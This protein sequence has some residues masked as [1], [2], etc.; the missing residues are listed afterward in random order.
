MTKWSV[1]C[2]TK[3]K[4]GLGIKN[5]KKMNV[6]LLCKWWWKI[7]HEEGLW[8]TIVKAKY[9]SGNNLITLIKHKVDDSPIWSDLLK[10]RHIYL[11]GRS[12][13]VKN[14]KHTLFW[15]EAW[16]KQNPLCSLYSVHYEL[17]LDKYITVN[18]FVLRNA[19]LNFSRWLPTFLFTSWTSLVDEIYS[20]PFENENDVIFWK[21]NN[22][23]KFFHK[24]SL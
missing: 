9:M 18:Q 12:T 15:E 23:G 3:R 5:I 2:K 11:R 4:G 22:N 21:L 7:E 10:I 19:Q 24:V 20:Y 6:S 17:C 16:F 8:Q 14:G 1:V 13:K